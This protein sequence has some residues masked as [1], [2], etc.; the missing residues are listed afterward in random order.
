MRSG[1]AEHLP[2]P[3]SAKRLWHRWLDIRWITAGVIAL[4]FLFLLW[5]LFGPEPAIRVSRETTFITEPLAADGLPDYH[6]AVRELAGPAPRPEA[7]AAAGLL[8]VCWPMGIKDADL[9]TVCDAMGIPREPPGNPLESPYND[10]GSKITREMC[11]AAEDRPWTREEF[12][13]LAAWLVSHKPQIDQLVAASHRA[14]YWLPSHSLTATSGSLFD[15]WM[16][17]ETAAHGASRALLY[18]AMWHIGEER[19]GDASVDIFAVYRLGRL[20][21]ARER[22]PQYLVTTL[23]ALAIQGR[24]TSMM[25]RHLLAAPDLPAEV[26][27][28]VRR[29][30]D[31]IGPPTFASDPV[32]AERLFAVDWFVFAAKRIPGGRRARAEN[33][34]EYVSPH[35]AL[36]LRTSLD[37][38]QILEHVNA[39]LDAVDA[40]IQ[41]PTHAERKAAL[42]K[43]TKRIAADVGQLES[44]FHI[45]MSLCSRAYRS[46]AVAT[47]GDQIFDTT[48]VWCDAASRSV[49]LFELIRTQAA[50]AAWH[51]DH[52]PTGGTYPG[53]LDE[54]VP[55]YVDAT[56]IDP[57]S[58]KPFIYERR[59]DGYLLASVGANG[60]YDGG[61]DLD[62]WIV[63][64]EWQH[65]KK[66][67][68]YDASDC[69]VRVPV[70]DRQPSR[71][72]N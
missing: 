18:R 50:L 27:A 49:V 30:V 17:T 68:A 33:M 47:E 53:R 4:T 62:G 28:K 36:F 72:A 42:Q 1:Q 64:G 9:P 21:V 34:K 51:A 6:V 14:R 5:G 25:T 59:G 43:R 10:A 41:L 2:S 7:N 20:L 55:R 26:L 11:E 37:W 57:F 35:A 15:S 31:A 69:V 66:D 54:L 29:D 23:T 71:S 40:A 3:G 67:V 32:L 63:K 48:Y 24:A 39:D 44:G 22:G 19:Y 60:A 65:E 13:E 46:A 58:E 61:S 45:P 8:Q 38:N 70:P 16:L 56:P 12:P 52:A